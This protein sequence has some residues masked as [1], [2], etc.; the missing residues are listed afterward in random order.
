M[1]VSGPYG[2]G[3]DINSDGIHIAFAAGTGVLTFMDLVA[4]IALFNLGFGGVAGRE[5]SGYNSSFKQ[6][7]VSCKMSLNR[8]A[9]ERED[10]KQFLLD[11]NAEENM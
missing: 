11:K 7:Q 8:A 3:L 2:K 4:Q 5:S 1:E 9:D 10:N 6:C